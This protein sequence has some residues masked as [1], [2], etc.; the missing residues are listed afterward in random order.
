MAACTWTVPDQTTFTN[1]KGVGA[2][3]ANDAP[4]GVEGIFCGNIGAVEVSLSA[5]N[6][7]TLSAVGVLECW[8]KTLQAGWC[9]AKEFDLSVAALG[10]A[11]ATFQKVTFAGNS[12]GRGIP[13][14]T[15]QGY[16]CWVPNGVTV[17]SGG[18]TIY[19]DGYT[20]R[21]I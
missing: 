1:A 6:G 9:R 10:I 7:Q 12:P 21:G 8:I 15:M 14:L 17:S 19:I 18:V 16:M 3:T 13:I 20:V 11:T 2:A 5:D 4:T